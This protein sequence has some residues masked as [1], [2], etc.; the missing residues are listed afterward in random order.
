MQRYFREKITLPIEVGSTILFGKF[1]NKK[2][3]VKGF[4]KDKNNQPLVQLEGGKEIPLLKLRIASLLPVKEN[5][6]RLFKEEKQVG[7]L[8]H[9]TNSVFNV[10]DILEYG[11][12]GNEFH[13]SRMGDLKTFKSQ[14][15]KYSF[16]FSRLKKV[17]GFNKPCYL[18]IDGNK[19]S[20]RYEIFPIAEI[21]YTKSDKSH[22]QY[23]ERLLA[24]KRMI[25]IKPYLL[26]IGIRKD[27]YNDFSKHSEL[28]EHLTI[29]FKLEKFC[30]DNNIKLE[31]F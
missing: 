22:S 8:Y 1:L 11:L 7:V 23:E 5:Y 13:A 25:D 26:E 14:Q 3:I 27:Y 4:S 21:G 30:K 17:E 20:Q 12:M 19:I 24:N 31:L 28:L 9:F 6:K 10:S 16:S 29:Y 15:D 18:K 2:G